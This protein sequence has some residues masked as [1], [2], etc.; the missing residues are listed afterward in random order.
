M[1]WKLKFKLMEQEVMLFGKLLKTTSG[2][3]HFAFVELSELYC[4][5]TNYLLIE[6]FYKRVI[7]YCGQKM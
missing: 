6:S 2:E 4:P 1:A 3:I 5:Q 7:N